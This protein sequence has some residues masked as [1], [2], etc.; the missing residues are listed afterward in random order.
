MEHSALFSIQQR[1]TQHNSFKKCNN[2]IWASFEQL[3]AKI[4]ERHR[5]CKK[6]KNSNLS[7][8]NFWSSFLIS[9]KFLTSYVTTSGSNSILDQLTHMGAQGI[10]QCWSLRLGHGAVFFSC[11]EI[12][13]SIQQLLRNAN[14]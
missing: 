8:T 5:K 12:T 14:K 9:Q 11:F 1:D 4:S 6:L 10:Y 2:C 7:S 13:P 3:V